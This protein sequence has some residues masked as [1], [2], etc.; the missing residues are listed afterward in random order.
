VSHR[1]A[2][3]TTLATVLQRYEREGLVGDPANV[4]KER[5]RIATLLADPISKKTL[6]QLR[7]TDIVA[8]RDR[9]IHAGWLRKME[10]AARKAEQEERGKQRAS[11]I[12]SLPKLTSQLKDMHVADDR[13]KLETQLNLIIELEKIG[14]PARTTVANVVQLV[15]RAL[16]FAA[17]T[18]DGVP[19]LSGVPMP[20][21]SPGRDRRVSDD[22]FRKLL[23]SCPEANPTLALV[24]RFAIH[25]ALRRERLL[26]CRSSHVRDIGGGKYALVFPRSATVRKKRTGIVPVTAEIRTIIDESLHLQGF[27]SLFEAPDVPIFNL[28]LQAFESQWR[29]L[30]ALVAIKDLH[31]HDFRH[32]ATSRLFERGL[33]TAEVMSITGHSTQE[34]VDRYSHYNAAL[35]LQKLER[36]MDKDAL[37]SEIRFLLSQFRSAGGAMEQVFQLISESGNEPSHKHSAVASRSR[38]LF[39]R[40]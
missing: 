22:E 27:A 31:F 4:A 19:D 21:C 2:E 1:D 30:I 26:T 13:R 35:V 18:I 16:K 23:K 38:N 25:T 9:L 10:R 15:T 39:K 11:E 8:L 24:I 12:R 37:L 7:K 20:T 17:Q 5:P 33:T 6:A 34:M 14:T 3:K 36:G 29:R 32:E 28:S 40:L